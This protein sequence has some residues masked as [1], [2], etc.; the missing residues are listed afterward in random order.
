M[1]ILLTVGFAQEVEGVHTS[2]PYL[3]ATFLFYL[4]S[5]KIVCDDLAERLPVLRLFKSAECREKLFGNLLL[6]VAA[7]LMASAVNVACV[8]VV[9]RWRL[10]AIAT[11]VNVYLKLRHLAAKELVRVRQSSDPETYRRT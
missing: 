1:F 9:G 8:V 2:W 6:K 11:Y 10:V 3:A 4:T 5:E 7:V